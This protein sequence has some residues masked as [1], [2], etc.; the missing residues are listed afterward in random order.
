MSKSKA[1][2]Y[3]LKSV[4]LYMGLVCL[5]CSRDCNFLHVLP[6]LFFSGYLSQPSGYSSTWATKNGSEL[7]AT[8]YNGLWHI[9]CPS[10]EGG[11]RQNFTLSTRD[12]AVSK[13]KQSL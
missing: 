1:F 12:I 5:E 4:V 9:F 8:E 2:L 10:K 11:G 7:S 3:A 13:Q 6:V